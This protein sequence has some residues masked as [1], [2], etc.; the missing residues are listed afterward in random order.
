MVCNGLAIF[1]LTCIFSLIYLLTLVSI[2]TPYRL[3]LGAALRAHCKL[4]FSADKDVVWSSNFYTVMENGQTETDVRKISEKR[5]RHRQLKVYFNKS[6][7]NRSTACVA[8]FITHI[9]FSDMYR[10]YDQLTLHTDTLLK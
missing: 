9:S 6:V 3:W 10:N 4:P 5:R 2:V 1:S 7:Q 8:M